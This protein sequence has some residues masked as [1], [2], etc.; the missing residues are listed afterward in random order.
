MKKKQLHHVIAV[1]SE[2]GTHFH[3]F[4]KLHTQAE[5][6]SAINYVR[7]ERA[8]ID[9]YSNMGQSLIQLTMTNYIRTVELFFAR[10]NS[11]RQAV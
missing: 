4:R 11:K 5:I 7:H 2:T 9:F 6:N 10:R 8:S 3:G 1:D